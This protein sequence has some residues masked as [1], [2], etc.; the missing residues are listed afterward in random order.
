MITPF[1]VFAML[2]YS[3]DFAVAEHSTNESRE[4]MFKDTSILGG[5]WDLLMKG[6]TGIS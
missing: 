3:D 1:Q 4:I 2:V 5:H 6:T